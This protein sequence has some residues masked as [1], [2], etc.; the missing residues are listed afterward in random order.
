MFVLDGK[1]FDAAVSDSMPK[2]SGN[3]YSNVFK[4]MTKED[5]QIALQSVPTELLITEVCLRIS[6]YENKAQMIDVLCRAERD[7]NVKQD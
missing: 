7:M 3:I 5:M 1:V 2:V 6:F 4:A